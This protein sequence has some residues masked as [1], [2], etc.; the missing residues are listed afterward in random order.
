[1]GEHH[2]WIHVYSGNLQY[3]FE[4]ILDQEPRNLLSTRVLRGDLLVHIERVARST[5]P[6]QGIDDW[7][8]I[9]LRDEPSG[10][11]GD[12]KLTPTKGDPIEGLVDQ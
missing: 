1:M 12:V 2:Y 7:L 6:L 4:F 9:R 5:T 8:M 11:G 3:S 10:E